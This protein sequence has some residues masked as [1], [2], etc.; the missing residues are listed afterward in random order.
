MTKA[1]FADC[2]LF[3]YSENHKLDQEIN[4]ICQQ[5]QNPVGNNLNYSTG[6][7][8]YL[9]S[10]V[11]TVDSMTVNYQVSAN[12]PMG[13]HKITNLAN[14][15]A[16]TDAAAFGQLF[17]FQAPV[18]CATNSNFTTT[19]ASYVTTNLTCTITPTSSSNR[20]LVLTHAVYNGATGGTD[21][22]IFRG[23]SDLGPAGGQGF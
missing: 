9:T 7:F 8:I 1:T 3:T 10:K 2:P 22:S 6:T 5:I 20:V 23:S 15:T 19:S 16:S 13:N 14:G 4:N 21:V 12:L 18:Y 11:I 17:L